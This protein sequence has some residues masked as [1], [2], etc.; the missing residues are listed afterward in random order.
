MIQTK[1]FCDKCEKE[2]PKY[3]DLLKFGIRVE[4]YQRPIETPT[5]AI[6]H[7]CALK[8]N[9]KWIIPPKDFKQEESKDIRDRLFDIMYE[10]VNLHN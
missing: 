1:Y 2:V 5:F 8:V 6:C 4:S 9:V 10:L 3:E 7:E